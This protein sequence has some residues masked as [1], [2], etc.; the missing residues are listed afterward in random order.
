VEKRSHITLTEIY[1]RAG[2]LVA[3]LI[4]EAAGGCPSAADFD[5]AWAAL[6]ALPLNVEE[7]A[8]ARNRLTNARSYAE[9][10]ERGAACFELRLLV[11]SLAR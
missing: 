11:L 8:V 4:A 7:A 1:A 9:A 6:E 10:G 3:A 5:E 2:S